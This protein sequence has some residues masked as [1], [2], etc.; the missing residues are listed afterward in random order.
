MTQYLDMR[1]IFPEQRTLRNYTLEVPPWAFTPDNW[2]TALL[3]GLDSIGLRGRVAEVGVGTGINEIYTLSGKH[4]RS[5]ETIRG[6]DYDGRT[7]LLSLKNVT[8]AIGDGNASR[9]RPHERGFSLLDGVQETYDQ[10]FACIPQV[11]VPQDIDLDAADNRAHYY[12]PSSV[13][14]V[15]DGKLDAYGLSLNAKLLEEATP[16]LVPG[17]SVTLNLSGRPGKDVLYQMFRSRNYRSEIVYETIVPQHAGTSL[18]TLAEHE[19]GGLT[20]EFFSDAD[21]SHRI[22]AT[23]AEKRRLAGEPVFHKIYVVQGVIQ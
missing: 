10:I 12:D 20:F 1:S 15:H 22:S 8:N 21:A 7:L 5:V 2:T 4:Y 23:E 14:T 19:R 13:R 6:S 11:P 17:G 18:S 16:H 9:Y 3:K